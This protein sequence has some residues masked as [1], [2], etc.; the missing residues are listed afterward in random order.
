MKE[1]IRLLKLDPKGY[2]GIFKRDLDLYL[3]FKRNVHKQDIRPDN[4]DLEDFV[5]YL[6]IEH[7]LGLRGSDTWSSEG[8]KTQ[9]IIRN[10]IACCL[11]NYMQVMTE[12]QWKLYKEFAKKLDPGD[13]VITFNYD[14]LVEESLDKIGKSYRFW[15]W[16]P[17]A[18]EQDVIIMK[19]HGSMDWFDISRYKTFELASGTFHPVFNNPHIHPEPLFPQ[20]DDNDMKKLYR[21]RD[22]HDYIMRKKLTHT[23]PVMLAPSHIKIVYTSWVERLWHGLYKV[24]ILNPGMAII[25]F[26]LP[27]HDRYLQQVIYRIVD[28]YQ[29]YNPDPERYPKTNIKII[30]YKPTEEEQKIFRNH[31]GF[32]DWART[33]AWFKGFN[34]EAL[35]FLFET[36]WRTSNE[37]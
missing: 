7:F 2:Y 36:C 3:E 5:T 29:N 24:G 14:T 21:V 23:S 11:H 8:N 22:I 17:K 19:L 25:G 31:Y 9:L 12:T 35:N 13:Y 1:I 37:S 4:V 28:E 32:V 18:P 26:S 15:Y 6:D 16:P 20:C 33:D 34:E 27:E 10:C 30:D